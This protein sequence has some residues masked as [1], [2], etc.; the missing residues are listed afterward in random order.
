MASDCA[1][2]ILNGSPQAVARLITWL[3]NEDERA[4]A[5]MAQLYPKTGKSYVIGIT[6]PPGAGKSTLTD[7]LTRFIRELGLTVGIVA[8]DPSSS[9]SKGAILGDRVRMSRL[10][11]D[12]GVYIRS[13][14]VRGYLGGTAKATAEVVMVLDASGKDAVIVETVGVGQDEVNITDIAD[15]TCLILNPGMGD[16]I[17]SMKSGFMEIAD[18]FIINKADQRGADQLSGEIS[19]RLEQDSKIKTSDWTPG[20]VKTIAVEDQGTGDLWQAIQKHR[21]YLEKSGKFLENRREHA[22][23]EALRIIHNE[24][25]RVIRKHLETTGQLCQLL[26][27]IRNRKRDPYSATREILA[28]CLSLPREHEDEP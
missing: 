2:E 11:A 17:Q 4:Y 1:G 9:H 16:A 12:P 8:T 25:F 7:S 14:A 3:E 20:I 10:N 23:R 22:G 13:M 21:S 6:G 28:R 18:I 5:C 27:D 15:T 24:L 19:L 26:E